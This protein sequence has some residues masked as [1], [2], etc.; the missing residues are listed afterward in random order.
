MF[1]T[2]KYRTKL[3]ETLRHAKDILDLFQENRLS[4]NLY[5]EKIDIYLKRIDNIDRYNFENF[6]LLKLLHA[7]QI[8]ILY[9]IIKNQKKAF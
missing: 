8:F 3:Q 7:N 9:D 6:N 1:F 4:D 5:K 2:K